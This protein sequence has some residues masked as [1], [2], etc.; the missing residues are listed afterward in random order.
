[1]REELED[2]RDYFAIIEAIAKGKNAL[3]EIVNETGSDRGPVGKYLSVLRELDIVRG[4]NS[5]YGK[6]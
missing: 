6:L 2:Q 5:S 1:M 3:G 4:K